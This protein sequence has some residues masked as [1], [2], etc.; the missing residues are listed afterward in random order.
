[1]QATHQVKQ[2]VNTINRAELAAIHVAVNTC[3][4]AQ[5]EA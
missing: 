1:M 3:K 2:T 5:G 4:E